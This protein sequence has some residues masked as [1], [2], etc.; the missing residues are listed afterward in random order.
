LSAT[1]PIINAEDT[2]KYLSYKAVGKAII[3]N[4]CEELYS[5]ICAKHTVEDNFI[6][7]SN[8]LLYEI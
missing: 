3:L 8:I 7:W 4:Y 6:F 1:K 5:T 2:T